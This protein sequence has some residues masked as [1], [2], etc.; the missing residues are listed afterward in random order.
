[1]GGLPC[2][3]QIIDNMN[4]LYQQMQCMSA[5]IQLNASR[6]QPTYEQRDRFLK[7]TEHVAKIT[8]EIEAYVREGG[9]YDDN[10]DPGARR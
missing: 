8:A 2:A 10:Y 5:S 3:K 6:V 9:E 7:A 1:M 4:A